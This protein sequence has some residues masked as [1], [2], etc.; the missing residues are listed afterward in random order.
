MRAVQRPMHAIAAHRRRD[1]GRVG[2]VQQVTAIPNS[3]NTTTHKRTMTRRKG[4]SRMPATTPL[5]MSQQE[6]GRDL[7]QYGLNALVCG[8]CQ[9]E[10][11]KNVRTV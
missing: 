3:Q 10:K 6:Q 9:G 4:S 8:W 2:L 11:A 5:A 1:S 7:C